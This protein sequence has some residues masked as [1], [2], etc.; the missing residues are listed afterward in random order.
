MKKTASHIDLT[1]DE[2][3]YLNEN[4]KKLYARRTAFP[5]KTLENMGTS[6][7]IL[8]RELVDEEK[9]GFRMRRKERRLLQLFL[10]TAI[11]ALEK[12][13]IPGYSQRMITP[14][15][16]AKYA[17]YLQRAKD[18]RDMISELIKKVEVGL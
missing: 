3:S 7:D 12:N 5:D 16:K 8:H 17:P 4:I 11:K 18:R 10:Q 14:K 9:R 2:F 1:E 13:I 6:L 15:S